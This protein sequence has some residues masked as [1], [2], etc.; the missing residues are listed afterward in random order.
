VVSVAGESGVL[1]DE[2]VRGGEVC[3]SPDVPAT[4]AE[5]RITAAAV[6]IEMCRDA[7]RRFKQNT[8]GFRRSP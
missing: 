2:P 3:A 8:I 1:D 4:R 5:A 7:K 6:T